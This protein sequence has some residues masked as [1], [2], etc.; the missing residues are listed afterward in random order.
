MAAHGAMTAARLVPALLCLAAMTARAEDLAA[1]MGRQRAIDSRLEWEVRDAGHPVLGNI[2]FAVLKTPYETTVGNGRVFTRVYVSCQRPLKKLAI[3]LSNTTAPDDPGGLKPA[4]MPRLVCSRPAAP[5]DR[6]LVQEDLFANW[7]VGEVGDALT[8]GYRPFPLR[9]CVSIA[10]E[11]EVELPRGWPQ[12]TA[13]LAFD[14]TPYAR[15]LDTVFVACGEAS[16]Y[17]PALP[18]VAVAAAQSAPAAGAWQSARV[19]AD[20]KTNVRAGP[21]LQSAI[22]ARLDPGAVILVQKS[23][24]DWW[25]V[26]PSRGAAFEGYVRQDRITAK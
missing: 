8:R 20:G 16:A 10:I 12:K 2:R 11:Q 22:V 5:G 7:E 15:E 9:E 1:T 6:K 26:R 24:G 17:G 3:E 13:R 25:R 19:L 23:A 18:P 21:N 14:I 4:V